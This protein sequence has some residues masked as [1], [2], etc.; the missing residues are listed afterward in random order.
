MEGILPDASR[1]GAPVVIKKYANRR[2]YD[3]ERSIYVTLDALADMVRSGRDFVVFD[4]RT[5]DDITR[6]VLIQIIMEEETRGRA[7]LPASFLRQ[8]IRFYGDRMQGLVPDYLDR[9]MAMFASLRQSAEG[10]RPAGGVVAPGNVEAAGSVEEEVWRLRR[11]VAAL[12]A[13][14]DGS[15]DAAD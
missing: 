2:L 10:R 3:T 9:A 6:S 8:I 12:Q 5:G 15:R 13:A 7:M 4:A 11:E 1:P 14:L